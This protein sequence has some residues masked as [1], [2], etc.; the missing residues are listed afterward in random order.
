M[1]TPKRKPGQYAHLKADPHLTQAK[2][3]SLKNLLAKLRI[4]QKI[5]AQEV[6]RLAEF[7][8]FSENHAYQMEKGRLRGI[9]QRIIETEELLGRASIITPDATVQVVQLGSRVT[10]ETQGKKNTYQILGSAEADPFKGIISQN[11]PLGAALMGHRVGDRVELDQKDQ[12]VIFS[13]LEIK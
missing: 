3:N 10:I 7:G 6:A 13:I 4:D 12:T 5:V 8:D 9:N 2:Y 1:Q 11:S